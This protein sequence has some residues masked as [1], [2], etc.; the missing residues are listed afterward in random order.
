VRF[1]T[2]NGTLNEWMRITSAGGV[3]IGTGTPSQR[4]DVAGNIKIS[5]GGNALVFP[6]GTVMSSAATGVGGG[7]ITGVTAG[8]GLSGGG[9]AGGIALSVPNG[10]IT[11]SMLANNSVTNANIADGSLSPAKVTGTAAT[12]GANSFTGNQDVTGNL[13]ATGTA[14][15]TGM[16]LPSSGTATV[17]MGFSSGALSLGA[18][19]F[20]SGIGLPVAQTFQWQAQPVGNN[21]SNASG[22]LS[23]LYGSGTNTPTPTGFSISSNGTIS[24]NLSASGQLVSTV[25]TGTAPLSVNS[26]TQVPNL[27]ASL[28]GGLPSSS[29]AQLGSSNTFTGTQTV[30]GDFLVGS[31]P[32]AL[33]PSENLYVGN[34]QGDPHITFRLD[35]FQNNLFLVANSGMGATSGAG[36]TFRTS[37]TGGGEFDRM[38]IGADGK[39][40]VL[41]TLAL[42]NT[43]SGGAG[44]ITFG[45]SPFIHNFGGSNVFVGGLA[46]NFSMTGNGNTAVGA[47]T[48]EGN[49]TGAFDTA[50][51]V[52]ALL[53]NQTGTENTA[54]GGSALQANSGGSFNTAIGFNAGFTGP[55]FSFA[56]KTG[57]SNT[58]IG[59][60]SGP[61]TTAQLTNATA[62][63]A[64]AMVS[65]SNALVLGGTGANAVNV[66]IGTSSPP[67]R[68]S[69]QGDDNG[70]A[71][72]VPDQLQI[73][74][75]TDAN[76][77]LLLGYLAD[78]SSTADGFGAIQATRE[79]V[80]DTVLALNP[81]GGSVGVGTS[82]PAADLEVRGPGFLI[83]RFTNNGTTSDKTAVVDFQSGDTVP[84]TW[85]V[86]V[87]GV[88]NG[89]GL[90][91]GQFY[92]ER[93]GA[94]NLF[95]VTTSGSVGIGTSAPD[96]L[97][98]VNGNAD[99]PGGGS[100]GTF[101]DGRLKNVF[102]SFHAGL[103][104][105]LQLH[106]IRY[107]YKEENALGIRDS[108]EHIGFVA[109]EVERVIPEAVSADSK[110]YLL[111][112]N[113]PVLWAMLNAIK[114]QQQQIEVQGRQI[115][116]QQRQ[117]HAQARQLAQIKARL[118][119]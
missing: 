22:Q 108:Q 67:V 5:G 114:E 98:T 24:G 14:T 25:P 87:G 79:F 44:I 31:V 110:G 66:G 72:S 48:F 1:L 36:I 99:K 26:T 62:I 8:A 103:K 111:L 47:T 69:V 53:S 18:S 30:T 32:N 106:P 88:G 89:L 12:L 27:N 43:T 113:D 28:L 73:Q 13:T 61:A 35:G 54:V 91:A 93:V 92:F 63:G 3:G 117:L 23:L 40:S 86:G 16:T 90:T 65:A 77:Q 4:L 81:R 105:V 38:T 57:S 104:E 75:A 109:Q 11:N 15:A 95:T 6:D 60:N 52:D 118:K 2:N 51:G 78:P 97:L 94:G 50:I 116:A 45:G 37:T 112:N 34:T 55:T 70:S 102:G 7:T 115:R 83:G 100:W 80:H 41:G 33:A 71:R 49:T 46:G 96:D 9:T 107:Q 74:G 85:R 10:G 59:F 17:S 68:L 39:V 21:T 119:P 56:N 20:N 101:S 42:P 19:T 64:N 84:T 76:K 58:F 82:T 29:F